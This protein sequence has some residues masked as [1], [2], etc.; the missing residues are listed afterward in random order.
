MNQIVQVAKLLRP[1]WHHVIQALLVEI[2][3][4]FMV[5]PGPYITKLLI[6]R[7]Y[8]HQDYSLLYFVLLAGAGVTVFSSLAGGLSSYFGEHV[9][10][11]MGYEFQSRFYKHLQSLDIG[12]FDRRETGELL[13]RFDDMRASISNTIGIFSSVVMNGLH[14][15]IFPAILFYIDWKLALISLAVLP[16]DTLLVAFTRKRHRRLSEKI[17]RDS[18]ELSAKSFESICGIRTVKALGIERNF[19]QRLRAILQRL[20]D[21]QLKSALLGAGSGFV[22]SLLKVAGGLAYGWYGWTQVLDGN[23]SVGT[24]LAFSGYVGYLYEPISNLI[25]LVPQIEVTL[26]HSGRFFEIY[27]RKPQIVDDKRMP[28]LCRVG[29]H[30]QFHGVSFSYGESVALRQINLEILPGKTI[31]LVGRSG[32]GKSTLAKLIP[33]FYDPC[34]GYVTIDGRDIRQCR[35]RSLRGQI[36]FYLQGGSLF[37]GTILENI[38]LGRQLSIP[39]IEAAAKAAKIHEFVSG[40]P[41]GYE[42]EIGEQGGNLSEGQRQRIALARVLVL[43]TPV[44][45]LD[46]PTA[47]LDC[48]AE[49]DIQEA[50]RN[51]DSDRTVIVIAHRL[52]TIR[53]ADEVVVLDRGRVVERGLHD[54]LLQAGGVY[55]KLH[56]YSM[57]V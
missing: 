37:Q 40:L 1:Y 26:V 38:A 35:L 45:I 29:G 16:F 27:H 9:G 51:A 6:D 23:L 24:Y 54:E 53:A 52:S 43:D 31:A 4:V 3:L 7:V 13:A 22:A 20:A 48:E 41:A 39:A 28:S 50:L 30:I 10:A 44:L 32:S 36:A 34:E 21:L 18:A 14:L 55:R 8:P 25:G 19:L 42:T 49:A 47:S 56:D 17:A 12:F 33:R 46:E 5:L 2:M 11:M 57:S 15:V